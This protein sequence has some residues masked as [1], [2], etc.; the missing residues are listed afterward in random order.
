MCDKNQKVDRPSYMILYFKV[1]RD[2][3]L[4]RAKAKIVKSLKM[5]DNCSH[6]KIIHGIGGSSYSVFD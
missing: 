1:I 2:T 6:F 3:R 5:N 4:R